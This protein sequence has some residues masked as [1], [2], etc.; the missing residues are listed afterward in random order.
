MG[1]ILR[2][3]SRL[4]HQTQKKFQQKMQLVSLWFFSPVHTGHKN[5][6]VLATMLI[7]SM[8]MQNWGKTLLPPLSLTR[9]VPVFLIG[10]EILLPFCMKWVL[11]ASV[12]ISWFCCLFQ[13]SRN[14]LANEPRVTRFK[15][16]WG[17][18]G[19]TTTKESDDECPYL[20]KQS[21]M[22]ASLESNEM[23]SANST[24]SLQEPPLSSIENGMNHAAM[25]VS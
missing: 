15:I 10:S 25:E 24:G 6:F 8:G 1:N 7:M 4:I 23:D 16:D 3:S 2:S 11:I 5:S 13:L 17:G 19:T 18:G 14:I 20:S 22:H 21:Q 12:Y 9:F